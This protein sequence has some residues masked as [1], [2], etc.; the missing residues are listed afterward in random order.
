MRKLRSSNCAI[1][2]GLDSLASEG[3][4]GSIIRERTQTLLVPLKPTSAFDL[5]SRGS[6]ASAHT[7]VRVPAW[8][9]PPAA[10][11][12]QEALKKILNSC[13]DFR[14]GCRQFYRTLED[15]D[16]KLQNEM[17][18]QPQNNEGQRETLEGFM[19]TILNIKINPF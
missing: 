12:G 14:Q 3:E 1:P 8:Q 10:N 13:R 4:D 19:E 2:T 7:R 17:F 9:P 16:N 5:S 15:A 11:A 6:V 18:S